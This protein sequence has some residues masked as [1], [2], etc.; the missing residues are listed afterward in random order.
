MKAIIY[1]LKRTVPL[2]VIFG[3]LGAMVTQIINPA[4]VAAQAPVPF[5]CTGQA[6]TVRFSPAQ[7]FI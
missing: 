6:F 3:L 1:R 7:L 5:T 4:T 2:L